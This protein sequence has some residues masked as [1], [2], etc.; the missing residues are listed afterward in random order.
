[1]VQPHQHSLGDEDSL[2]SEVEEFLHNG[3][4]SEEEESPRVARVWGNWGE[5][6]LIPKWREWALQQLGVADMTLAVD[7]FTA[8]WSTAAPFLITKEMDAFTFDWSRLQPSDK[9]LLWANP[10]FVTLPKVASKL[11]EEPCLLALVTPQWEDKTWWQ[12]LLQLPHKKVCFPGKPHL[13]YGG[14]TKATLPQKEWNTIAWLIDTRGRIRIT[15]T[16]PDGTPKSNLKGFEELLEENK[17]FSNLDWSH[18]YQGGYPTVKNQQH[19]KCKPKPAWMKK[20][21]GHKES[22]FHPSTPL[23]MKT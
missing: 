19:E 10:P 6:M 20:P 8:P 3:E 22:H 13:F 9:H 15:V 1:M 12:Q 7:L 21:K 18:G 23:W 11:E 5:Y 17:K 16:K 4:E 2:P 14:F